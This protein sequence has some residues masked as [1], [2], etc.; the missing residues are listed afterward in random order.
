[1]NDE[2]I[3]VGPCNVG[4]GLFTTRVIVKD[5]PIFCFRGITIGLDECLSKGSSEANV[6]QIG[7]NLYLD[8]EP[9]GVF[10]NH[11]CRPNVG[12]RQ[13]FQAIALRDIEQGEELRFDYTTTMSEQRWTMICRCGEQNCRGI[14][15]DFHDL[16]VGIQDHYLALGVVQPFIVEEVRLRR[17]YNIAMPCPPSCSASACYR[18]LRDKKL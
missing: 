1:M 17:N 10:I 4:R 3:I 7:K 14:I 9:P 6:V 16:P 13:C 12:I 15:G 5:E 2:P 18:K 8:V 11:S